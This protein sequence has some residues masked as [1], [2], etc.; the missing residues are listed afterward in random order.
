VCCGYH[1]GLLCAIFHRPTPPLV[2]DKVS[3]SRLT[4]FL[5]LQHGRLVLIAHHLA[6]TF[7]GKRNTRSM[8]NISSSPQEV[9]EGGTISSNA[10]GPHFRKWLT[11]AEASASYFSPRPSP[12]PSRRISSPRA[13]HARNSA[14]AAARWACLRSSTCGLRAVQSRARRRTWSI[15]CIHTSRCELWREPRVHNREMRPALSTLPSHPLDC[16]KAGP[17]N[18]EH[19]GSDLSG[20]GRRT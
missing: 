3:L 7:D 1:W 10:L 14:R 2:C 13:A 5:P 12:W 11:S 8:V 16:V 4:S 18:M 17:T 6:P 9:T 20:Q 19:V 15:A